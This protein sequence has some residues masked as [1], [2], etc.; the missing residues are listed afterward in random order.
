MCNQLPN[1]RAEFE[2]FAPSV[3][4]GIILYPKAQEDVIQVCSGYAQRIVAISSGPV[5]GNFITRKFSIVVA[6]AWVTG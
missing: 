2:Q 4:L 6:R 1:F 5:Y 3:V